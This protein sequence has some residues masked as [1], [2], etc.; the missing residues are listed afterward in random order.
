MDGLSIRNISKEFDG[1]KVLSDLSAELRSPGRYALMGKSGIGKTTLL[2]MIMGLEDP[3]EG[4]LCFLGARKE[5][6]HFSV[7]FQ[8]DRLFPREDALKNICAVTRGLKKETALE[9][10]RC[11]APDLPPDI[12]VSSL[13][14]GQRRRVGLVRALLHPSDILLLDE[15]FSGLDEA[16][17]EKALKY[18]DEHTGSRLLIM[19]THDIKEASALGCEILR[20]EDR[21]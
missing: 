20:L 2:R 21:A 10:L 3:D 8:E 16:T 15:P 17:K 11:I 7:L 18:T 12:P 4:E 9:E 1:I 14:G 5:E 13:S 19:T 6:V